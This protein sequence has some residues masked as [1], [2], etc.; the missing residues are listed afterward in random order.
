[1][2]STFALAFAANALSKLSQTYPLLCALP[3]RLEDVANMVL[4]QP[5]ELGVADIGC[6]HGLLLAGLHARGVKR[7]IGIDIRASPLAGAR[8]LLS[9]ILS[10]DL[11]LRQGDGLSPLKSGEVDTICLCGI[12][13]SSMIQILGQDSRPDLFQT[14]V[15]QPQKSRL[16][17]MMRLRRWLHEQGWMITAES[18]LESGGRYFITLR[19]QRGVEQGDASASNYILGGALCDPQGSDLWTAYLKHQRFWL[20]RIR[21]KAGPSAALEAQIR[22]LEE[23]IEE[24]TSSAGKSTEGL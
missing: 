1:M 7:L 4:C 10:N 13:A 23:G 3:Q 14:V 16:Q 11:E 21:S 20:E 2:R 6:D 8:E 22:S 15:L 17:D 18:I 24:L 12:G 5:L 19:A 9:P